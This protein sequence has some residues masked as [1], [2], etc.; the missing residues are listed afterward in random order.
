M[1]DIEQ[2][3]DKSTADNAHIEDTLIDLK[4]DNN[5]TKENNDNTVI[6]TDLTIK[7]IA[8]EAKSDETVEDK[9]VAKDNSNSII[10]DDVK[11]DDTEEEDKDVKLSFEDDT[12]ENSEDTPEI[13]DES[14]E[15]VDDAV[16]ED[17]SF[18]KIDEKKAIVNTNKPIIHNKA[19]KKKKKKSRSKSKVNTSIFGGIILITI[20]LTV[21]L[22]IA[23]SGIKIGMEYWGIGKSDNEVSFN[24]P[25]GSTNDDIATL[26]KQNGI[27]E[28]K[29]LFI[30]AIKLEKPNA[31]YPGDITLKASSGYSDIIATLAT[32]RESY[33]TVTVTIKEGENLLTVANRLEKKKVCT[34]EEFIFEFNKDQGFDFE[35]SLKS[36]DDSFYRMEGYLFPDTYEFYVGDSATNVTKVIRENFDKHITKAIKS[37]MKIA[38]LSLNQT[39]TLASIVQLEAGTT[40]SMPKIASVFLNRLNDADTYPMLQSDTTTNYINNVIRVQAET[41][42]AITHYIKCYDTYK[43]KGLPAGAICNPGMDAINAVLNPAKTKYYYF[44]SNLKTKKTYYAKTLAEHEK[45][46]KKAG[47]K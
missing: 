26:L 31:I 28:S 23:V 38:G 5:A 12:P 14:P 18:D 16:A 42:A 30:F 33:K 40:T 34:A 19:P 35:S 3:K 45:N 22:V 37:K 44:C 46:L 47:L 43:C 10:L 8:N 24:I 2:G 29:Q 9:N 11:T 27:I 13:I 17:V 15:K 32:M 7:D 21:S 6:D 41:D 1:D 20:I 4:F 39:I 25:K 36:S